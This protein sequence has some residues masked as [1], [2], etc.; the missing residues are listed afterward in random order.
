MIKPLP[1]NALPLIAWR[2]GNF[3]ENGSRLPLE[4]LYRWA[5]CRSWSRDGRTPAMDLDRPQ[6]DKGLAGA[7]SARILICRWKIPFR[8][9]K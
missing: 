8:E 1:H 9:K 2:P 6:N 3:S 4:G 7:I 5:N